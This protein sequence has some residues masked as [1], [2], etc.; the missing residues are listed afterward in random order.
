MYYLD[1]EPKTNTLY[2]KATIKEIFDMR[3]LFT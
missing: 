1:N 3:E 2:N